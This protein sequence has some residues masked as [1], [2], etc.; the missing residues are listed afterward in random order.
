MSEPTIVAILLAA[1]C[2]HGL[3]GF[4][5]PMLSTPVLLL[6]LELPLVVMVTLFPTV[7]INIISIS[8]EKQWRE[9][10]RRYWPIPVFTIAGSLLGTQVLLHTDP[11]PL[12]LLLAVLL[13]V[14]LVAER[15]PQAQT[16]RRVPPFAMG[17]FGFGLGLMGGMINIIAPAIVMYALFTRMDATLMVATFNF[18]FLI[19]KSGQIIGFLA[20]SAFDWQVVKFTLLLLPFIVLMLWLGMRLRKRMNTDNYKKLL[21]LSLWVIAL[22]LLVDSV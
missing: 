22:V 6:W 8:A 3:L 12:R 4:G 20:N 15:L 10:F 13:I 2:I 19:S 18:S 17:L 14:Y 11:Q 7:T 21:R 16:E 5:F 9:A 1:A